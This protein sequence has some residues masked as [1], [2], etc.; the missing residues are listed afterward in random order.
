MNNILSHVHM[1]DDK[2]QD[3][4]SATVSV[5]QAILISNRYLCSAICR[6]QEEPRTTKNDAHQQAT[7]RIWLIKHDWGHRLTFRHRASCI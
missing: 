2:S 7:V 5:T 4:T 6:W 1:F 3:L